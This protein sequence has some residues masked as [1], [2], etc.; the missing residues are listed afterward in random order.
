MR[1]EVGITEP[2]T[3]GQNQKDHN[4]YSSNASMVDIWKKKVNKS[5]KKGI[6]NRKKKF[7]TNRC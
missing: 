5:L 4:G 6:N 1:K 3:D 2:T 7:N